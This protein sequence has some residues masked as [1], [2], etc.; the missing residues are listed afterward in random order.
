M[1]KNLLIRQFYYAI[2][3]T[4]TKRG[5]TMSIKIKN[6]VKAAFYV[7]CVGPLLVGYSLYPITLF[8]GIS[9]H[10]IEG[11]IPELEGDSGVLAF[12]LHF[13]LIYPVN[14][15]INFFYFP[16]DLDFWF[17]LGWFMAVF[18]IFYW[19]AL[20][21]GLVEPC[22]GRGSNNGGGAGVYGHVGTRGV[23]VTAGMRLGGGW[24]SVGKRGV[25]WRRSKKLF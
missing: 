13:L 24:L 18:V 17:F 20:N 8:Y 15:V 7:C 1:F 4:Q 14:T 22:S 16:T 5:H 21:R 10:T 2:I 23:S 3:P 9:A 19:W 25:S 6:I 12:L 11:P